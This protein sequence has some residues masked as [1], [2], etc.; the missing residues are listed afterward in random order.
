MKVIDFKTIRR[1]PKNDND[2]GE[3]IGCAE[4]W[5]DG[6][7]QFFVVLYYPNYIAVG[8]DLTDWIAIKAGNEDI[9]EKYR[10]LAFEEGDTDE[11]VQEHK[12]DLLISQE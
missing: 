2:L 8:K 3:L 6:E 5:E 12:E 1:E 11:K 10:K 9:L 7:S 4:L